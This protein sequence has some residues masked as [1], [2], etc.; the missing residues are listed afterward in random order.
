[1]MLKY[2]LPFVAVAASASAIANDYQLISSLEWDHIRQGGNSANVRALEATYFLDSKTVL[3][4]LDQFE[5]INKTSNIQAGYSRADSTN[6]YGLGGEY[7]TDS[8]VVVS[9]AHLRNSDFHTNT[10]GL[11]Y[12]FSNDF[13]VRA[14]AIRPRSESTSYLFSASYNVQLEGNDYIGF[15]VSTDD[16]FDYQSISSKYFAALGDDR[17]ITVGAEFERF[18][19][20]RNEWEAEVGFY[21]TRMTSVAVTYNRS[22]SYGFK[23][24]HFFNQNWALAAGYGSNRDESGLNIW[25]LGVTGQF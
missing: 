24:K 22:K 21:F 12:L 11:G 6:L 4:P 25:H 10:L 5:Y 16:D 14:E 19:G 8:G 20:E 3:G 9:A 23:A 1:M 13:I 15:T 7:F 18:D 17:F 2:A